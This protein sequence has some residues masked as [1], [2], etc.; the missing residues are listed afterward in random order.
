MSARWEVPLFVSSVA[1]DN[2]KRKFMKHMAE[3]A[4]DILM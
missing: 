1:L 4:G 2:L 3:M